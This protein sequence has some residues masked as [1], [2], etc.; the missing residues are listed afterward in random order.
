MVIIGTGCADG[1]V[2]PLI[3][4]SEFI[5]SSLLFEIH[6]CLSEPNASRGSCTVTLYL[7][8]HLWTPKQVTTDSKRFALRS[9][10]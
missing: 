7:H 6:C 8:R 1:F 4:T 3:S 5:S 10:I 9:S 2:E